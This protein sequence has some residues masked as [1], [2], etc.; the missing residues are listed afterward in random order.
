MRSR[1]PPKPGSQRAAS[2]TPASRFTADSNR[3]PHSAP[4]ATS[5]TMTSSDSGPNSG[6][7]RPANGAR[8]TAAPST[9]PTTPS[10]VLVG[11]SCGASGVRPNRRPTMNAPMSDPAQATARAVNN[12]TPRAPR[13]TASRTPCTSRTGITTQPTAAEP[14]SRIAR[15]VSARTTGQAIPT[16]T[17]PPTS[18]SAAAA[19]RT[20]AEATIATF[21]TCSATR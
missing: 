2:L 16:R 14:R 19:P 1:M 20:A 17:R 12:V 6:M 9:L 15:P 5:T 3:S 4:M 18:H 21:A 7:S 11:E 13:S 10:R 8:P